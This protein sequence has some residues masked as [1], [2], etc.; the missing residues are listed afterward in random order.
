MSQ[1]DGQTPGQSLRKSEPQVS[2]GTH[3]AH[4]RYPSKRLDK[5]IVQ[6]IIVWNGLNGVRKQLDFKALLRDQ[7]ANE[8]VIRGAILDGLI[9]PESGEV[10]ARRD[11]R[12]SQRELDSVELPRH[13]NPGIKVGNNADRLKML[14][15]RFVM[16]GNVQA[17]HAAHFRIAQRGH[18]GS[19]I[20]WLDPHVAVVDHQ[21]FVASFVHHSDQLSHFVVDGVASRT[22]KD[23]NLTLGKI[24]HQLLK[25]GHRSVVLIADAEYQ[26]IIRVLLPAI[27]L[28]IFLGFVLQAPV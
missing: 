19:Q 17:S 18:H 7:S 20:I 16:R 10:R 26:L 27:A 1:R 12:L 6:R 2:P 28:K 3:V 25:N 22:I 24:T 13:E 4:H 8:K 23:S 9:T 14:G 11:D 21:N 5:K 15:N